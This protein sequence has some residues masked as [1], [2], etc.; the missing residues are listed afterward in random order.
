MEI[1]SNSYKGKTSRVVDKMGW[2]TMSI[3]GY[4]VVKLTILS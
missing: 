4:K 2:G 3:A 1:L